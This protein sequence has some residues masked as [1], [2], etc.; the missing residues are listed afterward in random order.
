MPALRARWRG[1]EEIWVEGVGRGVMCEG[2]IVYLSD[3][4]AMRIL[5]SG[6]GVSRGSGLD[7]STRPLGRGRT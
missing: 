3:C 4:F 7:V 5:V 6:A 1:D 2:V